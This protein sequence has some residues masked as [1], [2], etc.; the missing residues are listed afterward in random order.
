MTLLFNIFVFLFGLI[1]GSFLGALTYRLPRG[2]SIYKKSRSFCPKC[3]N[4]IAWYD[5]IPVLSYIVLRGRCRHCHKNISLRYP[6]IEL[7]T[8]TLMLLI[9]QALNSCN[10]LLLGEEMC[11]WNAVLGL[12]SYPLFLFLVASFMFILVVDTENMIILDSLVFVVFTLALFLLVFFR[13]N[14]L[15][16]NVFSGFLIALILLVLHLV[17]KGRG[18]GLGDSKLALTGGLFLGFPGSIYW[19]FLSFIIGAIA[20]IIMIVARRA[21]LGRQIPFGPF[22]VI[23]F[24]AVLIFGS[25]INNLLFFGL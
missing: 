4:P 1:I 8:A 15:Y 3:K 12:W 22:L 5:N 20:G 24:F 13:V 19:L 21:T 6:L 2:I 9:V 7:F 17:T 25:Y 10:T 14:V 11:R 18:M 23:S 16:I